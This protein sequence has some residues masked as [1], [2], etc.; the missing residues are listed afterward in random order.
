MVLSYQ[1]HTNIC[2]DPPNYLINRGSSNHTKIMKQL[3]M[4]IC[5]LKENM[6]TRS[7]Y[8]FDSFKCN[9]SAGNIA[10]TL[11]LDKEHPKFLALIV[12]R[13]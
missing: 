7:C 1:N 11:A 9:V 12:E 4:C 2:L 3:K 5:H 10:L 8:I 13:Y 6:C